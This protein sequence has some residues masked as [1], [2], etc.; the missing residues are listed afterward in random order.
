MGTGISMERVSSSS[1]ADGLD[2]GLK[3]LREM[4]LN[5][6]DLQ[7]ACNV[8]SCYSNTAAL[9]R[10]IIQHDGDHSVRKGA[11][12]ARTHSTSSSA[13]RRGN[14]HGNKRDV[15]RSSGGSRIDRRQPTMDDK[16]H[17]AHQGEGAGGAAVVATTK[18]DQA[19]INTTII[20]AATT[21]PNT[22]LPPCWSS[23]AVTAAGQKGKDI[24]TRYPDDDTAT[25]LHVDVNGIDDDAAA[26]T[27]TDAII[28]CTP[29]P[30]TPAPLAEIVGGAAAAVGSTVAYYTPDAHPTKRLKISIVHDDTNADNSFP[31]VD[32]DDS[33][34]IRTSPF[35]STPALLKQWDNSNSRSENSTGSSRSEI[36]ESVSAGGLDD[37]DSKDV[38][39]LTMLRRSAP[40]F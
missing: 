18:E 12:G 15:V 6:T 38:K 3:Q 1:S 13:A 22:V 32:D 26:P 24:N 10:F 37:E 2:G 35:T 14:V 21:S 29:A 33:T 40:A 28:P 5:S 27:G 9:H 36:D 30:C 20:K 31:K 16:P 34:M 39:Q 23:G 7:H 25:T 19:A 8:Q 4:M 11:T 17:R